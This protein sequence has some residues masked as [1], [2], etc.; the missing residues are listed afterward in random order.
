MSIRPLHRIWRRSPSLLRPDIRIHRF[1]YL[2]SLYYLCRSLSQWYYSLP[3]ITRTLLATF[4]IT[5]LGLFLG[6]LPVRHLIHV[7]D[8][9]LSLPVP[10]LWRLFT[11]FLIIGG[12]SINYLFQLVWLVRYGAAYESA[13]FGENAAD[14]L[15]M[16]GVGAATI[17]ALD[18]LLPFLFRGYIHGP[19]IVF[20]LIYLWSRE[21]ATTMVSFFGI[22]KL[23][24]Q[25]L[26]FALMAL[27][28]VQGASIA[29]DIAGILAGHMYYFLT[30]IFPRAYGRQIITTPTWL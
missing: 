24:G 16:L 20:M 2:L 23:N 6:V 28:M 7:W 11:N 17:L 22:I 26:P 15:V 29:G 19:S 8:K 4:L 18:G 9:E 3:P 30:D 13:R 27:D 25:W 14:A 10:Q 5:G 12:P 21:N 1:T